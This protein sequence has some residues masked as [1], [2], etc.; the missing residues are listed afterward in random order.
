MTVECPDCKGDIEVE[1]IL[2]EPRREGGAVDIDVS[3]GEIE[4]DCA[5]P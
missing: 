5:F 4:H 1:I 3:P 2:G